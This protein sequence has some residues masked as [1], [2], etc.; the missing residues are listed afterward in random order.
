M[1]PPVWT[2]TSA[3]SVGLIASSDSS[4]SVVLQGRTS[5]HVGSSPITGLNLFTYDNS[6]SPSSLAPTTFT[7]TILIH[8][9]GSGQTGSATFQFQLSGRV[10]SNAAYLSVLPTGITTEQLHVGHYY[11]TITAEPFQAPL[12][13]NPYGGWLDF[14]VRVRHNPEPSSLVLAALGLPV[15]G[16]VRRRRR[17]AA[18]AA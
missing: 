7:D 2:F 16:W 14:Q 9:L 6:S 13:A 3:P 18:S 4:A 8:D 10:A 1:S 17:R 11:Y 15:M 5:S 12:H